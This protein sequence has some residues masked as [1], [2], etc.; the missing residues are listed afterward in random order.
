M[1]DGECVDELTIYTMT[2]KSVECSEAC[3]VCTPETNDDEEEEEVTEP[4]VDKP[5]VD[6]PNYLKDGIEGQ[7]CACIGQQPTVEY[8]CL[9]NSEEAS[10]EYRETVFEFTGEQ[11]RTR[12]YLVKR[13]AYSQTRCAACFLLFAMFPQWILCYD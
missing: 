11:T 3:N 8:L 4:Q 12:I 1:F 6:N 7:D 10:K 2:T 5:C 9:E 13:T